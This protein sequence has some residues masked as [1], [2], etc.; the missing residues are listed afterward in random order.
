[1][2]HG[3][4]RPRFACILVGVASLLPALIHAQERPDPSPI[5]NG[6]RALGLGF[7]VSALAEDVS[8]IGWNPAGLAHIRH[9]E[10]SFVSRFL[11]NTTGMS[12]PPQPVASAVRYRGVREVAPALDPIESFALAMPFRVRGRTAAAG[13]AWRRFAEGVRPGAFHTKIITA[14]GAY[15]S[16]TE[17]QTSG[18]IRAL[19]PTLALSVTEEFHVGVTA[20]VLAGSISYAVLPPR[21]YTFIADSIGVV[22]G[23]DPIRRRW[24]EIDHSGITYDLGVQWQVT[25]RIRL[26]GKVTPAYTQ[27]ATRVYET[28]RTPITRHAPADVALGAAVWVGRAGRFAF[29]ARYGGWSNRAGDPMWDSTGTAIAKGDARSAHLAWEADLLRYRRARHTLRA[30]AFIRRT[31]ASD[32]DGQPI[33]VLGLSFGESVRIGTMYT[34]ESGVMFNRS[35]E[36]VRAATDLSRVRVRNRDFLV[37][38]GVRRRFF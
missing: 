26:A 15:Q 33:D 38:F 35:S 16:T 18:G 19:S 14:F 7:A 5:G 23:P 13:L 28:W 30:G 8:A 27:R 37:S 11:L 34:V 22:S 3:P 12:A 9:T 29:D 36:W 6:P 17:Y 10:G 4:A 21:S 25:P 2:E 20:N 32:L 24:S 31:T 1:V